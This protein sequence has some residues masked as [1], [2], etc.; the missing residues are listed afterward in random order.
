[1]IFPN[2][3]LVILTILLGLVY[4]SDGQK[5]KKYFRSDYSYVSTL[6][7]FYKVHHQKRDWN[8]ANVVCGL[9]GASLFYP[10][11]IPEAE[12]MLHS[13]RQDENL[14]V[15]IRDSL[16]NGVFKTIDGK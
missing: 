15:G 2:K 8:E 10:E 11:N 13:Y 7:G 5:N 1:M 3:V 16:G 6:Q 14:F 12:Q 9:E 4:S